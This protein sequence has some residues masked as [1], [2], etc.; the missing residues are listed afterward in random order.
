MR[1]LVTL[2]MGGRHVSLG[3]ED[4]QYKGPE[5]GVLRNNEGAGLW[6]R[7]PWGREV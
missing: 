3:Q 4:D 1:R 2:S 6:Y 7:F 5:A